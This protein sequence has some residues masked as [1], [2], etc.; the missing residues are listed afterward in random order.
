MAEVELTIAG[1]PYRVACR[2]GEEDNLRAAGALVDAKSREALAGLGA[3]S[4]SRQLL[5]AALLL[6]DQIVDGREVELPKALDP[7]LVERTD[8]IAERLESIA[9]TLEEA[10]RNA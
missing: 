3:L 1:R 4:E 10:D 2:D 5:F 8:R 7:A 9:D 6:A